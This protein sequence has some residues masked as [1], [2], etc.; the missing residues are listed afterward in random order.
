MAKADALRII[1]ENI[2]KHKRGK[3]LGC[4][5]WGIAGFGQKASAGGGKRAKIQIVHLRGIIGY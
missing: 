1:R 3:T 5:I 4:L 2:E